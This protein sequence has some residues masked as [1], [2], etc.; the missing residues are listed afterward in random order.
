[1]QGRSLYDLKINDTVIIDRSSYSVKGFIEFREG[2]FKFKDFLITDARNREQWLTVE[3]APDIRHAV[4]SVKTTAFPIEETF[5]HKNILFNLAEKG[6][7]RV[8]AVE[9]IEDVDVEEVISFIDF[10]SSDNKETVLSYEAWHPEEENS[11]PEEEYF[12]GKYIPLEK[13]RYPASVPVKKNE[14]AITLSHWQTLNKG[15]RITI[16]N[17]VYITEGFACYK[18]GREKWLEF[19]I[20][21]K[22]KLRLWLSIENGPDGEL[23]YSLHETIHGGISGTGRSKTILYDNKEFIL[24]ESGSGKIT[25]VRGNV[26]Y[27]HGEHFSFREYID[28]DDQILTIETWEDEEEAS[29]GKYLPAG[30]VSAVFGDPKAASVQNKNSG[31][32]SRIFTIIAVTLVLVFGAKALYSQFA[33]N[34]IREKIE[35]DPNFTYVTTVTVEEPTKHKEFVYQTAL[36]AD[37]AC[38]RIIQADPENI[39]YVTIDTFAVKTEAISRKNVPEENRTI[40]DILKDDIA[41][42]FIRSKHAT[43]LIYKGDDGATFVQINEN[44]Q[45]EKEASTN[46]HYY[47]HHYRYLYRPSRYYENSSEFYSNSMSRSN[48]VNTEQYSGYLNS[49]R[50]ESIRVR[51][52]SGGGT[53]FGK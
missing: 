39:D 40:S 47:R 22:G 8:T 23:A 12:E 24:N 30:S 46:R 19:L 53:S 7:A 28:K 50:Q 2:L 13:I 10:V 45:K 18:I 27:D 42:R 34:S 36:D 20:K 37:A 6:N 3:A 14:H 33:Q 44:P 38:K 5:T 1:M 26:D 32:A 51:N 15:S 48:N 16:G 11:T 43:I 49:A 41:Q 21:G 4:L 25:Q 35:K 31:T 29:I 17:E 9:G 52:L